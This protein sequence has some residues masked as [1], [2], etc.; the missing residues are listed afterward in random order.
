MTDITD[1]LIDQ[2]CCT[3]KAQPNGPYITLRFLAYKAQSPQIREALH[4]L[5]ILEQ[6][7]K[8][9]GHEIAEEIGKFRFLNEIIKIVSPKVSLKGS[10]FLY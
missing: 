7:V 8:R 2:L 5:Q 1:E 9:G 3:T 4:A 6:L 10:F